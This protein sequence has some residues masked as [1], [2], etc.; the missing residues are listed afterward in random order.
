[1][2]V[3]LE[4]IRTQLEQELSQNVIYMQETYEDESYDLKIRWKKHCANLNC[5]KRSKIQ[6]CILSILEV[7]FNMRIKYR[8]VI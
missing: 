6:G 3:D 5:I 1:M 8:S 2:G 7:G 4:E